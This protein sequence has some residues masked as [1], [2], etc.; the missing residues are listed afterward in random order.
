VSVQLL[1]EAVAVVRAA[2]RPEGIQ[3]GPALLGHSLESALTRLRNVGAEPVSASADV[4]LRVRVA[5]GSDV[6]AHFRDESFGSI[7][8]PAQRRSVDGHF[9]A[10][11]YRLE[12]PADVFEIA[13]APNDRLPTRSP[14]SHR[15][16]TS[17][18]LTEQLLLLPS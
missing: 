4:G 6:V 1:N 12:I 13:T 17:F 2:P 5:A 10:A 16:A 7:G 9:T 18:P 8:E 3:L 14:S 15:T 11:T